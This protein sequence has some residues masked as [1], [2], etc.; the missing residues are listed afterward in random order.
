M[1][2]QS[3]SHDP[4]SP[5]SS[6]VSASTHMLRP[7]VRK[8]EAHVPGQ[9]LTVA[10]SMSPLLGSDPHGTVEQSYSS[11]SVHPNAAPPATPAGGGGAAGGALS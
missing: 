10:I 6:Q 5:E 1:V 8:N 11:L 4:K 3:T 7:T 9:F 2:L